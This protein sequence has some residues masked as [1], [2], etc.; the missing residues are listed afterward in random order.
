MVK[1]FTLEE[2]MQIET[3]VK[4]GTPKVKIAKILGRHYMS[5][6]HEIYKRSTDEGYSGE[7]AHKMAVTNMETRHVGYRK[8]F[9]EN[10]IEYIKKRYE[11]G[12]RPR[13]IAAELGS[14]ER[15]V[16]RHL[17]KIEFKTNRPDSI[18]VIE[19]ILALEEQIKI[20]FEI[21]KEMKK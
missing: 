7:F 10:E 19:R 5:I 21:I 13:I 1:Y 9:S 14:S 17:K 12:I 2:R 8:I 6:R 4:E 16:Y 15:A 3:L 18:G 11:D 20:L